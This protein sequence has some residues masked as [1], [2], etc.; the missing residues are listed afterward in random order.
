MP[1]NGIALIAAFVV[2]VVAVAVY[3][4]YALALSRVFPK[5]GLDGWRGA[6]PFLNEAEILH[7]GGFP[8]WTIAI[9]VIPVVNVFGI[10]LHAIA[11]HRLGRRLGRG[12][13]ATVLAVLLPPV[14]ASV[15][16]WGRTGEPAA[17]PAPGRGGEAWRRDPAQFVATAPVPIVNGPA[18]PMPAGAPAPTAAR[19]PT[20]APAPAAAAAPA[21]APAPTLAPAPGP[22]TASLAPAAPAAPAARAPLPP[23]PAPATTPAA[24]PTSPIAPPSWSLAAPDPAPVAPVI[25]PVIAPVAPPVALATPPTLP[26]T[27]SDPAAAGSRFAPPGSAPAPAPAVD[28]A[29]APLPGPDDD[30]DGETVVVDRR[31]TPAW[32]LVLDEGP[33]YPIT[34]PSVVLG[35]RPSGVDPALQYLAVA[36]TTRTLSKVHARLDRVGDDWRIID[37]GSTNG[38]L[39]LEEDGAELVVSAGADAVL[40][41]RRFV[42]GRV[43]MRLQRTG[44]EG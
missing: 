15:L 33:R 35:R 13:G 8:Y 22:I 9:V 11:A 5:V 14:W 2:L 44:A 31:P 1:D 43:A 32:V 42:L 19:T 6:V 37:L 36:D 29:L 27:A 26:V 21:A 16:A 34:G 20:A 10:V 3:V 38:V 25:A 40:A 41:G 30:E 18:T 17:A 39:V 7:L 23:P 24:P 4:W 12:A 28:P